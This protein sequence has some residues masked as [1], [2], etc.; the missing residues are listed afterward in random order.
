VIVLIVIAV[1]LAAIIG[2]AWLTY[3]RLVALRLACENSWSQI[4]VA[5]RLRHDLIPGLVAAV[6]GY[7]GHERAT[8]EN[9]SE[10]RSEAMAADD[11]GPADR[12]TA[13]G[14]LG[15][16]LGR[17]L[18]LSEDYPDLRATE[19]FSKLQTDLAEVEEKISI[20]R[21][22]YNDTVETY[23]TKIQVFPSN[24]VA[25]AFGFDR[26]EFFEAGAG[27]EIAPTISLGGAGATP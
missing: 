19:N 6:S 8:F 12:G 10:L 21:R 27:A 17:M 14:R 2:F 7:A 20:T 1:A 26:R 23:N 13:E 24:L 3:N 5:L 4:D 18:L 16:S 11:A 15:G 9:V 22:V 25:N